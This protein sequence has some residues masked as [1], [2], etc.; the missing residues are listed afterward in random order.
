MDYGSWVEF[1]ARLRMTRTEYVQE[2]MKII[3]YAQRVDYDDVIEAHEDLKKAMRALRMKWNIF[4]VFTKKRGSWWCMQVNQR[5]VDRLL[6]VLKTYMMT[7]AGHPSLSGTASDFSILEHLLSAEIWAF[8]TCSPTKCDTCLNRPFAGSYAGVA[9]NLVDANFYRV[10]GDSGTVS[11][12][13]TPK[14]WHEMV[15][16]FL[17]CMMHRHKNSALTDD[18]I[19]LILEDVASCHFVIP[20]HYNLFGVK[21]NRLFV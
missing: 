5:L 8:L 21:V 19:K 7:I 14:T 3:E 1:E 13:L 18:I 10:F 4:L 9:G 12:Y 17:I 11:H 20:K 6:L 2:V 16:A 15:L